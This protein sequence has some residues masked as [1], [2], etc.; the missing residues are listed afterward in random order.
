M[1]LTDLAQVMIETGLIPGHKVDLDEPDPHVGKE[2]YVSLHILF[3][4]GLV[5]IHPSETRVTGRTAGES[6]RVGGIR[7]RVGAGSRVGTLLRRTVA[8]R[9]VDEAAYGDV[10]TNHFSAG[11]G[12]VDVDPERVDV[13]S[14]SHFPRLQVSGPEGEI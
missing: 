14:Q 13:H 1:W 6:A 9:V 8:R 5:Y 4:S 11:I 10:R 3:S 2:L 7:T 12:R